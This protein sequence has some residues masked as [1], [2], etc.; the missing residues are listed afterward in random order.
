[1]SGVRSCFGV[2][3]PEWFQQELAQHSPYPDV[4]TVMKF[5]LEDYIQRREGQ[6]APHNPAFWDYRQTQPPYNT[7]KYNPGPSSYDHGNGD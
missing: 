4:N 5:L 3:L 6:H 1:M 7:W 2:E